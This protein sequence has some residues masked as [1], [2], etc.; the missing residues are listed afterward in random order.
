MKTPKS[1]EHDDSNKSRLQYYLEA[2]DDV[3]DEADEI[4]A[5]Y[6]INEQY[7]PI[8]ETIRVAI[9]SVDEDNLEKNLKAKTRKNKQHK[10]IMKCVIGMLVVTFVLI[11]SLLVVTVKTPRTVFGYT[12][13]TVLSD[14]MKDEL[15]RGTFIVTKP[16]KD[17]KQLAIDDIIT[18]YDSSKIVITHRIIGIYQGETIL[19]QTQGTNNPVP[20]L[21]MVKPDAIIGKV[22]IRMPIFGKII[23]FISINWIILIF[24][25]IFAFILKKSLKMIKLNA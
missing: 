21:E 23:T 14:S 18:F 16:V 13:F 7:K 24:M 20:D 2:I 22:F 1:K 9:P 4:L 10:H 8:A 11:V 19:F 25:F 17:P 5:K 3:I 6:G 12:M 15:P